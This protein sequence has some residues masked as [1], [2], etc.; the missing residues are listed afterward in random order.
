MKKVT[1]TINVTADLLLSPT[2]DLLP[3]RVSLPTL[4]NFALH[5]T[6]LHRNLSTHHCKCNHIDK[7]KR[8]T[9]SIEHLFPTG[10]NPKSFPTSNTPLLS[11]LFPLHL[12]LVLDK[13][14]PFHILPIHSYDVPVRLL[15]LPDFHSHPS[16]TS[17]IFATTPFFSPPSAFVATYAAHIPA[18]SGIQPGLGTKQLM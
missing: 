16:P 8:F 10:Q 12:L 7:K 17:I 15:L 18:S 1:L 3:L 9:S 6:G 4:H 2:S 11:T 5:C 13:I 14:L